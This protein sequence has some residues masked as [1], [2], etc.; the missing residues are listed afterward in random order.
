MSFKMITILI[1][2]LMVT[3]ALIQAELVPHTINYQGWLTDNSPQ[4]QPVDG[5]T[6]MQ[7]SIYDTEIAGNQ[8]W[9]ENWPLVYVSKGIFNVMLGNNGNPIPASVFNSGTARYLEVQINGLALSP[10]QQISAAA[11]AHKSESTH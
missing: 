11:Y 6:N 7:F 1:I 9:Q 8:L 2:A 5:T 4:Q 10:R 3:G